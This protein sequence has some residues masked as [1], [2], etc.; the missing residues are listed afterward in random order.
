MPGPGAACRSK[1]ARI[2]A[3]YSLV[4]VLAVAACGEQQK[5]GESKGPDI[6]AERT[7]GSAVGEADT[8]VLIVG[9][10][11]AQEEEINIGK[12]GANYGWSEREGA[13]AVNH[14]APD[15]PSDLPRTMPRSAS[16]IPRSNT[17][18]A[19]A[20]RS[21]LLRLPWTSAGQAAR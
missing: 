21:R 10:G 20:G 7:A 3:F 18:T 2:L 13:S 14:R 15:S 6:G 1:R 11:Q 16:P 17:G 12:A 8:E 9:I 4:L 19:S 5:G